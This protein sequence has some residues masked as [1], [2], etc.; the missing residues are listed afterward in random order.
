MRTR[1]AGDPLFY[2]APCTRSEHFARA[3]ASF[4]MSVV[5]EREKTKCPFDTTSQGGLT[6]RCN[7]L[8]EDSL[9]SLR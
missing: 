1:E 2:V 5:M 7:K 8:Q 3:L 4:S 6:F 9:A